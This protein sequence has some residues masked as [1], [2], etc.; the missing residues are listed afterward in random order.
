MFGWRLGLQF[1]A[2]ASRLVVSVSVRVPL[3][4]RSFNVGV[5]GAPS[6]TMVSFSSSN[7]DLKRQINKTSSEPITQN[8]LASMAKARGCILKGMKI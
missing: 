1:L 7:I 2:N 4:P 3:Q 5:L 8:G 6:F